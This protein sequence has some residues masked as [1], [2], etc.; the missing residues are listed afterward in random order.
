M[1]LNSKT[2][3]VIDHIRAQD[4]YLSS[5][6]YPCI[7]EASFRLFL[8]SVPHLFAR[9]AAILDYLDSH[10]APDTPDGQRADKVLR[11]LVFTAGITAPSDL[12]LLKHLFS[13]YANL[14]ILPS[15]AHKEL[16]LLEISKS[17]NLDLNL[18]KTDFSFFKSRGLLVEVAQDVFTAA[19]E[20][21]I[22]KSLANWHK[23]GHP[24]TIDMV[25][26]LCRL[27]QGKG[28]QHAH[29]FLKLP[30]PIEKEPQSWVPC[31]MD[32]ECGARVV[33]LL[34]SLK[35]TGLLHAPTMGST[36]NLPELPDLY[37]LL[38][39]AGIL[40][41]KERTITRLG[42]RVL[43]RGPGP[44]GIVHAYHAYL[45][46]HE[47]KLKKEKITTWV[48]RGAN[49]AASQDANK[50]TFTLGNDSL[51]AYCQDT[52]YSYD[53]FIE[54]AVGQGEATR[55]R[56]E[57]SGEDKIR[58]FGADLEDA[59]IDR[60]IL[61][62]KKGLLPKN[63]KFI[64]QADIGRPDKITDGLSQYGASSQKAVM[65]VGNGFHE[66]R[67]QSNEKM[68]KVFSEY[69]KAGILVIFTEESGLTDKDLLA[70]GFNTYHAGFRYVHEISGQGLRPVYDSDDCHDRLSW[71]TCAEKGGYE[72]LAKY[73]KKTRTIYPHPTKDG[74][75]PAISVTYF[76]VPKGS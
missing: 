54:H 46:V 32:I 62:Q 55:Q 17:Y 44:M 39:A 30:M 38:T 71:Q 19:S 51:D 58:Y 45:K 34:L 9:G 10:P 13:T 18:M 65:I 33:P 11:N 76:C 29:D 40:H 35:V 72:V 37:T 60:A 53:V 66:V 16:S 28:E 59:A 24:N 3:Q 74:R 48:Q 64:R 73:T 22:P 69:A 6:G 7:S 25:E 8:D 52:G 27:L 36:L 63:M 4:T 12:W 42:E 67:D 31:Q 50:K 23:N 57:R 68:V 5:K 2:N 49:V 21:H 43:S 75:S 26:D 1:P 47:A 56:L 70:T 20:P 41:K 14:G 15:L 61:Q